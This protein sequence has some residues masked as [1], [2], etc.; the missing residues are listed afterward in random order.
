MKKQAGFTMIEFLVAMGVTLVVLTAAVGAI[1]SS[2]WSNQRVTLAGDLNDNLRASLN[3][4]RQDIVLAGE[5]IPFGGIPIPTG[6]GISVKRPGPVSLTFPEPFL[7]A[8]TLGTGIGPSVPILDS[9]FT[10]PSTSA[11]SDMI[12]V[13]YVDNTLGLDLAPIYSA[14]TPT[15]TAGSMQANGSSITFDPAAG[16]VNLATANFTLNPGDLIMFSNINGSAIQAVTSVNGQTVNFASNS[17]IDKWGLNQTGASQGTIVQI[18]NKVSGSS[19][20]L[21]TGA[22][23]PTTAT[24]IW[25]VS[26]YLDTTTDPQHPR[27]VRQLNFGQAQPVAEVIENIQ[28]RYN[29]V[30]ANLPPT[31]YPNYTALPAGLTENNIRAVN[32]FLS[33]RSNVP[34]GQGG[35]YVRDNMSTQI[36]VRNLAFYNKYN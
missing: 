30:D 13:I 35:R 29:F 7:P 19:P 3:L 4:V 10:T 26:Y 20:V 36:S 1:T 9:S 34:L 24:R 14:A 27:L 8:I 32:L 23:P 15:C 31:L 5:G 21:Y 28:F 11:P 17:A 18:Q 33:A 6:T 22:Y 2:M 25:M 16:C 12:T